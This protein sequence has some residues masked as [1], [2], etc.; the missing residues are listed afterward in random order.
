MIDIIHLLLTSNEAR[1]SC[2]VH[3]SNIIS[4]LHLAILVAR[5]LL[6]RR[7][8]KKAKVRAKVRRRKKFR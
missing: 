3:F 4:L 1:E 8:G 2:G 7:D 5:C 6:Q